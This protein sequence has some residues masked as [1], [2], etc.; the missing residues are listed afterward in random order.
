M[1]E[2]FMSKKL[3]SV[4]ILICLILSSCS[5]RKSEIDRDTESSAS[6]T[7]KVSESTETSAPETEP[8]PETSA[9]FAACGDNIIYF[10]TYRD[11]ASQSDGSRAYNFSPIYRNVKEIISSADIAFINQEVPCADSFEPHDYPT[12]NSPVDLTYDIAEAGFDIINLANN[13]M[14]DQGAKGIRESYENWKARE[15]TVIGCYEESDSRYITYYE[16]NNIKI[17]FVSYT[18]GTNLNEDPANEGLYAPYLKQ[19]DV[20][21]DVA[22]AH[23]N[24][25]FVIVS[26]HWGEEGQLEPNEEQRKYAKIMADNGADVILG[27]HPHVLQPIEWLD[28]LDGNKCLCAFSLGNFVHEQAYDYNVP[29]GILTFNIK[30]NSDGSFAENVQL[31]PTVCHY[32]SNFYN[33]VVYLFRDYT[34]ELASS[35]AVATYYNNPISYDSLKQT[36]C[37][38]I[39]GEFLPDYMN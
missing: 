12:F 22:E 28:G 4:L 29:G 6:E 26:V 35:H 18:Y 5:I 31:I 2:G 32:P 23:E 11:A 7:T 21:G 17:A 38:T 20:A 30:K 15:L 1:C 16:K 14:L 24:A 13:H 33:N 39:S 8:V 37:S 10:G 9:S 34:P 36:I 3:I 19:S 25:D 27:H